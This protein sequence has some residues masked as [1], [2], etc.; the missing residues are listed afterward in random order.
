[1]SLW[2]LN[3]RG[4][5]NLSSGELKDVIYSEETPFWLWKFLNSFTPLGAPPVYL[6]STSIP[7][8][9]QALKQYYNTNG[10][11]SSRAS[12]DYQIDTTDKEAV[13]IYKIS[14]GEPSTYGKFLFTGLDSISG[15]LRA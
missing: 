10:F 8:D 4:M 1:M 3:S 2:K 12:G 11:F 14:E 6:D 15:L 7:I 13:L 9:L 5:R